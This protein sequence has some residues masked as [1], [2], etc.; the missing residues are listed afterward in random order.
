MRL[1]HDHNIRFTVKN[2]IMTKTGGEKLANQLQKQY[3]ELFMEVGPFLPDVE[4][5]VNVFDEPRVLKNSCQQG[6]DWRKCACD[7][8]FT[9]P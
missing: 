6:E 3:I 8:N 2:R 7:S 1:D 9:I 4:F 5:Y